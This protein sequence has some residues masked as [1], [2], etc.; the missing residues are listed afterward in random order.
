MLQLRYL[1]FVGTAGYVCI[2]SWDSVRVRSP[3]RVTRKPGTLASTP[4]L[5]RLSPIAVVSARM[6]RHRSV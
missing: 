4:Q 2:N 3:Q 1:C 5:S 6:L